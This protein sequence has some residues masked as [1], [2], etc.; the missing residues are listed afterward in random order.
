MQAKLENADDKVVLSRDVLAHLHRLSGATLKIYVYICSCYDSKPLRASI[1]MIAGATG[2][3]PRATISALKSLRELKLINQV[4]GRGNQ[5][6]EYR[7]V[8][9]A[10]SRVVT[11]QNSSLVQTSQRTIMNPPQKSPGRDDELTIAALVTRCY[12]SLSDRETKE[13]KEAFPDE[14]EL[15]KRLREL[16]GGGVESD[17][18]FGFFLAALSS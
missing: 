5:R 3:K 18:S 17:L 9:A 2:L 12:R 11:A 4:A 10:S 6:N 7:V 15:R 1:A 8:F 14:T 16:L 13:L